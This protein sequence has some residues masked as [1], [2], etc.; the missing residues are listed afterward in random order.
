MVKIRVAD[1]N[2]KLRSCLIL[3]KSCEEPYWALSESKL[4]ER[5]A[6]ERTVSICSRETEKRSF[7][8]SSL[9]TDNDQP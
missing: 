8:I 6:K 3:P 1:V 9:E 4:R 5:E 2:Q 7:P